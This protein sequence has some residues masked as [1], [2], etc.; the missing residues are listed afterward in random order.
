M[1]RYSVLQNWAE[2]K[3][4]HLRELFFPA[5][6]EKN[7]CVFVGL[8][9][10]YWCSFYIPQREE[11]HQKE[12]NC[13]KNKVWLAFVSI[14]IVEILPDFTV[15]RKHTINLILRECVL[16][17][18]MFRSSS[19]SLNSFS[20]TWVDFKHLCLRGIDVSEIWCPDK[21]CGSW[22]LGKGKITNSALT[23][24]KRV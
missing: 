13:T 14:P 12:R 4:E 24:G 9:Y 18:S 17:W 22:Q 7:N 11:L 2:E 6:Q 10:I 5:H 20:N 16:P 19:Y 3:L 1:W 21:F 8:A 23:M 15:E